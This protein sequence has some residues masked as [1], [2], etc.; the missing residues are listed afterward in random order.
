[1][2]SE[3]G[4]MYMWVKAT[5]SLPVRKE[6]TVKLEVTDWEGS[7]EDLAGL[8]EK[9]TA[10]LTRLLMPKTLRGGLVTTGE[11]RASS[12]KGSVKKFAEK[13]YTKKKS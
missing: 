8:E 12:K 11:K 7:P 13:R 1:M 3:D 9:G 10:S 2:K 5:A 4:H 6:F